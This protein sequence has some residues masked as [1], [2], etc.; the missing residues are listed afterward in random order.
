MEGYQDAEACQ[1]QAIR[2]AAAKRQQL[3]QIWSESD[4]KMRENQLRELKATGR[5]DPTPGET[6]EQVRA[7]SARK[8]QS[9][10]TVNGNRVQMQTVNGQNAVFAFI[11]LPHTVDPRGPKVGG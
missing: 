7:D 6:P 11:C 10:I 3:V 4:A 9:S 2:L 8:L 1:A 5:P